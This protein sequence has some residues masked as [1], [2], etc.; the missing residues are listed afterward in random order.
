MSSNLGSMVLEMSANYAR[1]QSDI[2]KITE[3][4]TSAA[5]KITRTFE[6]VGAAIGIG[7]GAH[8]FKEW[9]AGAIEVQDQA[10]KLSQK[11]GVATDS[12]AG[13]T[14]AAQKADIDQ[15]AFQTGMVKLSK[16]AAE[17]AA[18]V[19]SS[20]LAYK[21]LG[22]NVKD[23]S[24]NLKTS[25]VL[26]EE[27]ADKF[28]GY[29]D[30]IEK[31]NA[32]V[33]L[34]GK[35]GANMI[36][37]LNGGSEAIKRQIQL[38]KDLGAAIGTDAAKGA[39]EFNDTLKDL[40]LV[41]KGVS[42]QIA[43]GILPALNELA[44][45]ALKFFTSDTWKSWLEKIKSAATAV[46]DNLDRIL[47]TVK[48]L[49][50]L[51]ADYI[52]V[53]LVGSIVLAT[54]KMVQLTIATM[55]ANSAAAEMGLSFNKGVLASIKQ[56]GIL[57][58]TL[59]TIGAAIGGWQIGTY[60]QQNFVQARVAGLAFVEAMLV[61]WE[62]LK[63]AGQIVW[64]TFEKAADQ[65]VTGAKH[66]L[67]DLLGVMSNLQLMRGDIA[68]ATNLAQLSKDFAGAKSNAADFDSQ[69]RGV[70]VTYN[71][72]VIGIREN[73]RGLVDYETSTHAA[74]AATEAHGEAAKRAAPNVANLAANND[75]A[76]KAGERLAEM[77]R[78]DEERI[79]S[80]LGRVDP[81]SKAYTEWAN[82]I[83]A[84]VAAFE[85]ETTEAKAAGASQAVYAA[86][87]ANVTRTVQ[88]A[89]A[90]LKT[91]LATIEREK[92][93]V[94]QVAQRYKEELETLGLS[95]QA[96]EEATALRDAAR[97]A[98]DDYNK[99][100]RDSP[101]LT[102]KETA[103]L[104]R[105]AD[106]FYAQKTAIELSVEAARQ[107][108]SIWAQAGNAVADTFA[109]V[110]VE[111]GSLF[112]GLRDLAKQTV[113]QIIAYFAKLSVI[114]PILNSIFGGSLGFSLLP[115]LG[116]A[117]VASGFNESGG[118]TS[119]IGGLL[120]GGGGGIF[121]PSSWIGAGKNLATGFGSLWNGSGGVS[122]VSSNMFGTTINDSGAMSF[123][124]SLLGNAISIGGG[125]LSAYNEY[126]AG[127]GV[128][129]AAAYGVGTITAAGAVGG[130]LGG[131]GAAAGASGA[132]GAV[133]LGA[134]PVVGWIALAAM[135]VDKISG[136]KLFGTSGKVVGGDQVQT[137][138]PDGASVATDYVTKGQKAFFG[139]SY[140]KQHS[141][142]TD[143]AVMQAVNDFYS[144]LKSGTQAFAESVKAQFTGI[145]GGTF[146]TTFDAKGNPTG[147]KSTVLGV[148]RTG[149]TQQQ[150][151][152][153]LQADSYLKV[154]DSMGLAASEFTKGL[155]ND[156]DKLFAGVQD[157]A[158]ATTAANTDLG[159]GFH[160]LA[161]SANATLV[162]V[163][164]FVEGAQAA[165]ESL[166]DTYTRLAKAQ[167]Q[168]NQF[169]AQFKPAAT[170]VDDFEGALS[171]IYHTML[172]NIDAANQLAIAAGA[173]GAAQQDLT[174]IQNTAAQQMAAL[175]V[176]LEN[177]AQS[178]AFSLGLTTQ[179]SLSQVTDEI[180]RLQAKAGQTGSATQSA[181]KSLGQFVS[182]VG[183][184]AKAA[185]NAINLLLGNLSPLN[186]QQKLQIALQGLRAGTVTQEQV[187]SIGRNLYASS[188]A[189]TDLF[190]QVMHSGGQASGGGAANKGHALN[191]IG[192]YMPADNTTGA[193]ASGLS[194]AEQARLDAL[195]K[196]QAALQAAATMQQYQT[197]ANQIAE[198][199]SAKGETYTQILEE[200]GVQ[201]ADLEKGLGLKSDAD[202]QA[203]ITQ[204]QAQMDSGKENTV[205]IVGALNTL[206]HAI[207]VELADILGR[208]AV[209]LPGQ[210]P[211]APVPT[212][213]PAASPA[214]PGVGDG[215]GSPP[216]G[217]TLSQADLEAMA[218]MFGRSAGEQIMA[219]LPRSGRQPA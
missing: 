30:G 207:A 219:R 133:G 112:K 205:S 172:Q 8:E 58:T 85:K 98:L 184:V 151:A 51:A 144:A 54:A 217:R 139:G 64:L 121:S 100:L 104:K 215:S 35:A 120:G 28:S 146:D 159:N 102:D 46:A 137:I 153:R 210:A 115:Q 142:P 171:G 36:P 191:E 96:L 73:I 59:G 193:A 83:L 143:P 57:T 165:G 196:Q 82:Q 211:S 7:L 60:L 183:D 24:G 107:W 40:Q 131:A 89:D 162:D 86:I 141:A 14:S 200:M 127:G 19:Q 66:L 206:P 180:T 135:I 182:A 49:G 9:I 208:V 97:I 186:D 34:F 218:A 65:A 111:G 202:L 75:A 84:G 154:L 167:S 95:G 62:N 69:M 76:A 3:A 101:D 116:N 39:E 103:A 212:A 4:A 156:A 163:M 48:L 117:A 42:N 209:P 50:Q 71:K 17:A 201:A 79:N 175:T 203:Y 52:G 87:K 11:I 185:D 26:L 124:P 145:V 22:I 78:S 181:T 29:K 2:G 74:A 197:L 194:D 140:W 5:D 158:Q 174:N 213:P 129:G 149:E 134:I 32:A 92:D 16:S 130:V 136:G 164:K 77:L 27:L 188:Q 13:L 168:Y 113:E 198:I 80:I 55:A 214:P 1:F 45:A 118:G 108:Q 192:M 70:V 88:A 61:G 15:Q 125:L 63:L 18:G 53:R 170:Y 166:T 138:G 109:K 20:A 94:G 216:G 189:Y 41:S 56:I 160:F 152:E 126:K 105:N 43:T 81:V 173:S 155:Q 204:I 91:H 10:L 37:L 190:N 119:A 93:V 179:G 178:L 72:N 132:L 6:K 148:T 12:I 150:F 123:T 177:S 176:Q 110:L 21:A 99:G 33:V 67:S 128:L 169:T 114:N 161:L 90:A 38:A 122:G 47:N 23:A 31:T 157:F 187:L 199:A 44:S 25:D 106:G 147:T 68:G 195:L